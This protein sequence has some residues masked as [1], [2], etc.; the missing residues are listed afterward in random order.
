MELHDL[1]YFVA[2]A[3]DLHFGRAAQRL[4]MTQ[5]ALSRQIQAL[6][7][8]LD[9]QLFRRSKRSVQLTIAGQTFFEEAKQILRHTEQAIQT[10]KRVAR[11]EVGQLR[12]SFTAS[13]LRSVLPEIVRVFRERYPDVQLTMNERCTHDQ[14]A[15]FH[16][17]QVDVGFLYLPVDEKLLTLQPIAEEVWIVALPKGHHL[18]D[19]KHL[20]LSMLANEA[21]ILHPRQS[22]AKFYDR[23]VGLCEQAGFYPNVVQ[24]VET[25]Q[26]RV[27][28]V[29]AGM[30][31][32][33]VPEYLQNVGDTEV[34]YRR[35]KGTAPKLQLA[36][37]RRRDNFSPIVQ[38]FL[39]VVEELSQ[40]SGQE[41]VA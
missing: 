36:I 35:L 14:V 37:A 12:L 24:E 27:G 22:G 19:R 21:F 29:A 28:L 23:I 9:V 31:I 20:T 41:S 33:F 1:R 26:T 30:G 15:A 4:H 11:G 32:T 39:H 10:T 34:I 13:A 5:P 8:E 40:K 2:V 38:Q 6:E 3:E 25:S 17:H 16:S 7:A 18:S